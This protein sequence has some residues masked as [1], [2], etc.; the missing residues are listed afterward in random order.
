MTDLRTFEEYFY[1]DEDEAREL[2]RFMANQWI[3]P[4]DG[5]HYDGLMVKSVIDKLLQY[6]IHQDRKLI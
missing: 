3:S 5:V 2:Y 4:E 6:V 1:L